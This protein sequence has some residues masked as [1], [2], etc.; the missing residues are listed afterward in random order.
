MTAADL[1]MQM[2]QTKKEK[3]YDSFIKQAVMAPSP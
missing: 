3:R 2:A 1:I